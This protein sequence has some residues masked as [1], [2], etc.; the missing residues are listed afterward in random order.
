MEP[1]GKTSKQPDKTREGAEKTRTQSDKTR[2]RAGKTRTQSDK[3]KEHSGFPEEQQRVALSP[4]IS[5]TPYRCPS[6]H[7][8]IV[9][10][11]IITSE[12]ISG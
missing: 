1:A 3:T 8:F 10:Q 5:L 9:A 6:G 2:E 4:S 7:G 11:S 12:L